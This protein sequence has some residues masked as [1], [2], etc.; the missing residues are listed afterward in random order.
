MS[1]FLCSTFVLCYANGFMV[2][3]VLRSACVSYT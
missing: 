2:Y 1:I 3:G